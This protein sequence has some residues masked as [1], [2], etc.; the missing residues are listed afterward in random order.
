MVAKRDAPSVSSADDAKKPRVEPTGNG[1]IKGCPIKHHGSTYRCSRTEGDGPAKCKWFPGTT[2]KSPHTHEAVRPMPKIMNNIL[3]HIG[4]TPLVRINRIT[5]SEGV[6]AEILAKC[7]FFNAGG[8]VKDR[9]GKRMFED[10]ERSGRI[11]PGDTIIEPTS[12]NTGIG[13]ALAAAVKGYK[14]IVTLPEKMS[15]EKVNVLKALGAEIVRTPTEAAWDS[16][17]SHIG[18]ANRLN[19]EIP[20]SHI[21][22]QYSNPSNPLAH[23]DGTAEELL[24]QC[25]GKIDMVVMGSG[26]GGTLTGVARKIKEKLPNCVV[27]GVD[28]VGSIL[29][30]PDSLNDL[31][32]LKAYKVEGTGYDFIPT[33]LDREIADLWIKTNDQDSLT[34]SRRL[35]K[36]E[37]ILC[38]GSSGGSMWAA[39]E[40]AKK[41]KMG[42][43][44]RI[45]VILADSTRN[46][47]TKFLM[48][49]WMVQNKFMED[50]RAKELEDTWW[51]SK[52]VAD[53]NP[54]APITCDRDFTC[55]QAIG[56]MQNE[57]F[58]QLPVVDK[59]KVIGVVTDGNLQALLLSG[60][61]QKE[62][63]VE[64]AVFKNF[65]SVGLSTPLVDL[66][67]MFDEE[68]FAL[69]MTSQQCYT[70]DGVST[71]SIV[72]GVVSRID[73]INFI[74]RGPCPSPVPVPPAP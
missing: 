41:Y 6:D 9:I 55:K 34:M 28:P 68:H 12:G 24:Q 56:V 33:V 25:D 74:S 69:V 18:V 38:G 32:R 50:P 16:P 13:L 51:A 4:N 10:A 73:L 64:K 21:L 17:E 66:A 31:N 63:T 8:S 29:A 46:Y 20:N 22:D 60:R 3:E 40:A 43:D 54:S 11:K 49:K 2:E 37:G 57:G 36:E 48:D 58:D 1:P 23:Y 53:L 35:I 5:Q 47:M 61:I 15:A 72:S 45:V 7:E 52:T 71:N 27:V 26:T 62:D 70:K 39:V 59:G 14:M 65:K 30:E 67:G 44:K 42:K 19:K